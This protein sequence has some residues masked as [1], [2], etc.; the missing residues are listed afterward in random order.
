MNDDKL[1]II[2]SELLSVLPMFQKKLIK[3]NVE[4]DEYKF[5]H[6]HIQVLRIL[7]EYGSCAISDVSKK[8]FI[9]MPN[10]TKI[11]NKLIDEGMINRAHDNKD[12]RVINISLTPKGDEYLK[13]KFMIVKESIRDR[14]SDLDNSQI[15]VF[16]SSLTSLKN[17]LT[18]IKIDE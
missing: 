16:A 8:L 12:R 2:I 13:R 17:I 15:D 18:Q 11:L 3:P 4:H 9:S 6:T 1:D 10:M 14:I 7:D 5:N